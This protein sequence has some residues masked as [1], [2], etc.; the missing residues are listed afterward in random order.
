[1]NAARNGLSWC[2]SCHAM[3]LWPCLNLLHWE[4]CGKLWGW[5]LL[6][7]LLYG[8]LFLY[9]CFSPS[10]VWAI[11]PFQGSIELASTLPGTLSLEELSWMLISSHVLLIQQFQWI[12][13]AFFCTSLHN[14][15]SSPG[16]TKAAV[17]SNS[18]GYA[19]KLDSPDI[20][21]LRIK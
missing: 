19:Q 17:I 4:C 20:D 18:T 14:F 7:F 13:F 2:F 12:T 6:S 8:F 1:M 11:C 5:M 3:P 9:G 10:S 16:I 21:L 15:C